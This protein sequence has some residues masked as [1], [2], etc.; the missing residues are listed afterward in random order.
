MIQHDNH[1][2]PVFHH[3]KL[4]DGL[5][6]LADTACHPTKRQQ[7]FEC[8]STVKISVKNMK[9]NAN[10]TKIHQQI[11]VYSKIQ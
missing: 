10:D 8:G 3:S 4:M 7:T 5:A 9:N 2:S 1:V 11:F 6:D